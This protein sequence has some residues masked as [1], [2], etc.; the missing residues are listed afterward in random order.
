MSDTRKTAAIV[1]LI[2]GSLA[3]LWAFARSA[4]HK[5][6]M[7]TRTRP[8]TLRIS[9]IPKDVTKSDFE[10]I[11]KGLAAE[12]NAS[13]SAPS[14]PGI[15]GWSFAASGHSEQSCIATVTFHTSPAPTQL[16][17]AIKR[18]IDVDWGRLRVDLDF[19]GFTPLAD[20]SD[21]VVEYATNCAD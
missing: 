3:S 20:P 2:A 10:K 1:I 14:D 13:S 8:L 5:S 4:S 18:S 12:M 15:L 11:L 21:P 17:M 16:Q 7:K 9:N 19:F 6:Q